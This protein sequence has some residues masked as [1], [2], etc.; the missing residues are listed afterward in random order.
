MPANNP[1]PRN[2]FPK[3]KKSNAGRKPGVPNKFTAELKEA[4]LQAANNAGFV[5][6]VP[7][8][9][10]DGKQIG[11]ELI[12][13]EG[14]LVGYLTWAAINRSNAFISQLGRFIPAVLDARFEVTRDPVEYR[15]LEDVLD[16]MRAVGLGD[17]ID[18]LFEG[19]VP[20]DALLQLEANKS[21]D[22]PPDAAPSEPVKVNDD[23]PPETEKPS[24]A[25][26]GEIVE[27]DGGLV[28]VRRDR[29]TD[30]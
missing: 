27:D 3:G 30:D 23:S 29:S 9:D 18:V 8:L 28:V 5:M 7:R 19:L 13:G 4:F 17:K 2:P 21:A 10:A 22:K 16:D 26:T 6:E 1:N 15:P 14:G 24:D 11:T 20:K 25:A 12:A